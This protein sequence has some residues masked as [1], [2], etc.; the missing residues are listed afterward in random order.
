VDAGPRSNHAHHRKDDPAH[1]STGIESYLHGC[2]GSAVGKVRFVRHTRAPGSSL[3]STPTSAIEIPAIGI[4]AWYSGVAVRR[5]LAGRGVE[6]ES[7]DFPGIAVSRDFFAVEQEA[8][9]GGVAGFHYD[10]MAGANGCVGGR[11]QRFLRHRLAVGVMETQEVDR[12][13]LSA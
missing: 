12:R 3:P 11:D 10:F 9:A 4:S 7:A 8:D 1:G 6:D 5:R 2:G 13:E